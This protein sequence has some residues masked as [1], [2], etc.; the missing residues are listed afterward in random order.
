[1]EPDQDADIQHPL[2]VSEN[3][4]S[5]DGVRISPRTIELE[6]I[7]EFARAEYQG[8]NFSHQRASQLEPDRQEAITR[9]IEH[10]VLAARERRYEVKDNLGDIA[11]RALRAC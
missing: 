4:E 6:A 2:R 10:Q 1:M 5:N 8:E 9:L 7:L 3:E 11:Y